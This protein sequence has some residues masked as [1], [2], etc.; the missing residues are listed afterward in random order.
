MWEKKRTASDSITNNRIGLQ[1]VWGWKV[2]Y[3]RDPPGPEL[4][5][6]GIKPPPATGNHVSWR[7]RRLGQ[8]SGGRQKKK[9]DDL[10]NAEW[11]SE[12]SLYLG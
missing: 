3:G 10:V 11:V 1:G 5:V 7:N 6:A 9:R 8:A 4:E 12:T 2:G